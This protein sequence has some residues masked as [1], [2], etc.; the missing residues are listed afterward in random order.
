M[1]KAQ[2]TMQS[3]N[4][5]QVVLKRLQKCF[6]QGRDNFFIKP[7]NDFLS[8]HVYTYIYMYIGM[9]KD[10]KEQKCM[11][12]QFLQKIIFLHMCLNKEAWILLTTSSKNLL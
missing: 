10:T 8:T 5:F 1:K 7:S 2:V 9:W 3:E 4:C 11:L 12:I 6:K